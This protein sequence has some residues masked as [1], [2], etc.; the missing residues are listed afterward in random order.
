MSVDS[1]AAKRLDLHLQGRIDGGEIPGCTTHV[2][3]HDELF[4]SNA[5]G[6]SDVENSVPMSDQAICRLASMTKPIASVALMQ[7]YEAGLIQLN[8]PVK[9]FISS[10]ADLEVHVGV[11]GLGLPVIEPCRR[12]MTVHDL[13]THQS[14]LPAGRGGLGGGGGPR[15]A[16]LAEM[17]ADLSKEPLLFQ[18]GTRYSYGVSTDVVGHLV[19]VVTGT[20]LDAYL[21]ENILGPLGMV[22]TGFGVPA[23]RRDRLAVSYMATEAGLKVADGVFGQ[24]PPEQPT[25]FSGAGGLVG[26]A[27]DYG[28]FA[29][30]LGNRG[31]LDG[32]R[33]IAR[34]TLELMTRNHLRRRSHLA[35]DHH[36]L[37]V[38]GI[39]R[40]RLRPRLRRDGGPMA[41][42]A[43][44]LTRR[45]LLD[46]RLRITGLR[47]SDRGSGR[48]LHDPGVAIRH[49]PDPVAQPVW[50]ART[51]RPRLR[52][53]ALTMATPSFPTR[54]AHPKV[55]EH[56]RSR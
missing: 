33:V 17:V 46:R 26:T 2:W 7:C 42:P 16:T 3:L 50:L 56:T 28:R 48:G 29:R 35:R 34:K 4:Y 53:S 6:W 15:P 20:P 25:Y 45:I 32:Q 21:R 8:D 52:P 19:E 37:P 40:D 24:P 44:G 30:M 39:S 55:G 12:P 38:H 5:L 23:D 22:D 18:P 41:R 11:Q 9:E 43:V 1:A 10:F 51:A 27:T 54:I 31:T 13:L 36:R 49:Q 47:R 14:G